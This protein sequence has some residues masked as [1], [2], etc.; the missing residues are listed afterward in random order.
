[1]KNVLVIFALLFIGNGFAQEEKK[2][3]TIEIATSAE[4][5]TCKKTLEDKLN[6][7]KGIRYAEL[8]VATKKLTVSYATKKISAEEIRKLISDTGYDADT[9]P[10]NATS[11]KALPT[12][13]QPGGMSK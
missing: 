3:Q 4:C 2:T 8:D 13:C 11:Q 5:G 7:T 9:V 12:C 6:Y 1:M 10:A